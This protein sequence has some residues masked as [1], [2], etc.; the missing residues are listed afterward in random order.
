M[1]LFH[2]FD[3][4]EHNEKLGVITFD[5]FI[6][7]L[8]WLMR[9]QDVRIV[10]MSEVP[11]LS[12]ERYLANHRIQRGIRWLPRRLHPHSSWVYLCKE[13]ARNIGHPGRLRLVGFYGGLMLAMGAVAFSATDVVFA[14]WPG[15]ASRLLWL[16]GPVL[17]VCSLVWAF[18]RGH[19]GGRIRMLVAILAACAWCMGICVA[20]IR[21]KTQFFAMK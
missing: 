10:P 3:F 16:S 15:L 7:T 5:R 17:L 8:Q 13:G 14:K 12:N 19:F 18:H 1:V 20:K 11:D 9:Q 4:S 21:R 6:E 2:A